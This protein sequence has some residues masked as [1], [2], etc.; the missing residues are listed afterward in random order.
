MDNGCREYIFLSEFFMVRDADAMKL[1][2]TVMGKTLQHV[3]VCVGVWGGGLW[4]GGYN[5]SL[6]LVYFFALTN[7]NSL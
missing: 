4:L 3:Q 2:T 5:C 1:F 7:R 6:Q